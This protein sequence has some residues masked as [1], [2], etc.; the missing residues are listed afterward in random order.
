MRS[1]TTTRS[2]VP[3]KA[4]GLAAGTHVTVVATKDGKK[5]L[6]VASTGRPS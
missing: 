2:A 4:A 3:A 6:L 1:R 5:A